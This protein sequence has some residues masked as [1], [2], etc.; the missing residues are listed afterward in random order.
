[1]DTSPKKAYRLPT[2]IWKDAQCHKSSEKCK[3]K[4]QWGITSHLSECLSSI[5]KQQMLARMWR[6]GNPPAL[7]MRLWI[8]TATVENSMEVPQKIKNRT[9]IWPSNSTSGCLSKEIQSTNLK[10]YTHPNVHCSTTYNSHDKQ[11]K[12]SSM[13]EQT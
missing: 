1:M 9:T 3:L 11:H 6:K 7:L 8:G 2:D 12:C 13:D 10:R 4:P 5:S